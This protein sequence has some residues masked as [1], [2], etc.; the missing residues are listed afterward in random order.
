MTSI[1]ELN[2]NPCPQ[3]DATDVNA[4]F[5]LS[6]S[7]EDRTKL[8]FDNSWGTQTLD[9][10]PAIKAGETITHLMLDPASS[11]EY[12]RFDNEAGDSECIAGSD[13]SSI[14]LMQRLGDVTQDETASEGDFYVMG[15]DDKFHVRSIEEV[16]EEI[17][18]EIKAGML[19]IFYPVGTYYE[20][21]DAGFDPNTAWG[22]TWVEDT[23]G[24]TTVAQDQYT[25]STVGSTGG[26][27]RHTL[28]AS[29]LPHL[30]GSIQG[31]KTD[32]DGDSV[33]TYPATGSSGVFSFSHDAGDTWN[34]V[35]TQVVNTNQYRDSV[36]TYDNGGQDAPHNN[37]QP[38]IVVKRWHRVA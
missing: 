9:L 16:A 7:E 28:V 38:Y 3:I 29:E 20:T 15:A 6:L 30:T 27:E 36:I 26:E 8:I 13:L 1:T 21:S 5:D 19:N 22:G 25:F 34:N 31:R 24:R 18:Q 11:P 10:T 33:N 23:A 35:I 32:Y 37:L 4:Y 2:R 17:S 14:I 12:L